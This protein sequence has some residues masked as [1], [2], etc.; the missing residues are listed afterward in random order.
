MSD[1][2][3]YWRF[4]LSL[5]LLVGIG[6][7]FIHL[8]ERAPI[9]LSETIFLITYMFVT[10][11]ACLSIYTKNFS[12]TLATM[13]LI[14]VALLVDVAMH[15]SGDGNLFS[16]LLTLNSV[17]NLP[18]WGVGDYIDV[19]AILFLS[20]LLLI[21]MIFKWREHQHMLKNHTL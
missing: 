17:S 13:A 8:N 5:T 7:A 16:S 15:V 20:V 6:I 18:G 19:S 9:L 11:S 4:F 14:L 1:S 21:R 10:S 3:F 2:L 12:E